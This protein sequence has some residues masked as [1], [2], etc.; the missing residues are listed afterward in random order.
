MEIPA[1]LWLADVKKEHD[2][3]LGEKAAGMAEMYRAGFS[4]PSG[5]VVTSEAFRQYLEE[6][7]LRNILKNMLGNLDVGNVEDTAEKIQAMLLNGGFPA[8][9][10]R[11]ILENYSNL[12]VNLDVFKM[13]NS[14]TL[15]MIKSGRDLPYVA[16]RGC[17]QGDAHEKPA[18]YLNVRGGMNILKA[19]QSCWA[20]L[21]SAAALREREEQG[22]AQ[23]NVAAALLIQRQVNAEKSGVLFTEH[24]RDGMVGMLIEAGF[25]YGEA[26]VLGQVQP[27]LYMVDKESLE[28]KGVEVNAKEFMYTR[29]ETMERTKKMH[30]DDVKSRGQVFNT[31]EVKAIARLGQEIEQHYQSAREVEFA[32]E[33]GRLY[34]IQCRPAMQLK[35]PFE[36]SV[37]Q[38]PPGQQKDA[39]AMQNQVIAEPENA[40][41]LFSMLEDASNPLGPGLPAVNPPPPAPFSPGGFSPP[42]SQQMDKIVADIGGVR[43]ELPKTK[44]G[45]KLMKQILELIEGQL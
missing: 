15:N 22:I 17:L 18:T 32:L 43:I 6:N 9:L 35:K 24:K 2:A 19:V 7:G 31:N 5:F 34:V 1:L 12:N 37:P 28:L 44:E 26:V 42:A 11:E 41:A 8:N 45:V 13:V 10:K 20:S 4:V 23:N 40:A 39:P 14:S 21:F 30:L 16:V 29:D 33:N 36:K 25:G 27:D 38:I 3:E